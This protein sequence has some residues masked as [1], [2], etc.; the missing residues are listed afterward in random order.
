MRRGAG[1]RPTLTRRE[2]AGRGSVW[3]AATVAVMQ[4]RHAVHTEPVDTQA[5][6]DSVTRCSRAV[7]RKFPDRTE[8]KDGNNAPSPTNLL[9]GS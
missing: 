4:D 5:D 6:A 7:L 9:E 8:S 3:P 1:P 2:D